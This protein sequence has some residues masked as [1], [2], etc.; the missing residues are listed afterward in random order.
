[1]PAVATCASRQVH[2]LLEIQ[3]P[4]NSGVGSNLTFCT[5]DDLSGFTNYDLNSLLFDEDI[6]GTWSEGPLTDQLDDLTDNI[7]DI[8]AIRDRYTYGTF[9][10]EYTVFPSH[11][12]CTISTTEVQ[13]IFLPVLQGTMETINF[14]AG[15]AQHTINITNY[16]L[17]LIPNGTYS[18]TYELTSA[19]GTTADTAPL[20]LKAD[21]TGSFQI[22]ANLVTL[23]EMT[24]LNITT[25]GTMVCADIQVAPVSFVV[26]DPIATVTD[27]CEE[28][29]L[30]V[31]LTNIFD[32][33]SGPANGNYDITYTL[34]APSGAIDTN[35]LNTIVFSSGN[36]T[37]TIPA[38][39][40]TETGN[41]NIDFDIASGF[42][43]DCQIAA[44]A[45]ITPI[46]SA[47][48]L[49][50]IVNNSCNATQ[51]DVLVNAPLLV[52]G[53]YIVSY[54]V[55]S[56]ENNAVLI[57]NTINFA[58]GTAN[59][60][61]DVATLVQGNYTINVRSTQNDTTP[62]RID[63]DFEL[64]EN[65]AIEGVPAL[66]NAEAV[67]FFCL[68]SF[69]PSSPTLGDIEV[70]ANG[71]ILF[72]DT[73]TDMAILPLGT[74]LVDNEDYFISNIDP[75]NN[76]EGSDRVQVTVILENP[77][78][79]MVLDEN[80]DFCASDNPTVNNLNNSI[81]GSGN[82]VWFELES[83]G[84]ALEGS[85][86]LVDGKSYFA[87]RETDTQ[88]QSTER[89]EVTAIVYS[90]ELAS[91]QL[92]DL[93]LCGLD[94]PTVSNL[95]DIE[96]NNTFEI[97]WYDTLENGTPLNDTVL[98]I[99]NTTYYAE[100]FDPTTGCKNL[101]RISVTV[102]LTDCDP[103]DYGFFIPDGF[104]PNSD[105]RN[106]TFFIPDIE[107]IFPDYTLEILN[108]YGTRLFKGDRNAPAWDGSNGS[109]KATNGVY[110]YIIDYNKKGHT[111]IQGRLYLNR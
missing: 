56:Q 5:T 41:Y 55:V 38:N 79:P 23:N 91:I 60:Q 37:F 109:G 45:T 74:V 52:D 103:E 81:S 35:T 67:Q 105:G 90:L 72:Y 7:I 63:F 42:P 69:A 30:T 59:Y 43:L 10:F 66:P 70:S 73:A 98:L 34:N 61:I 54:E 27:T 29:D 68:N 76:C 99:L 77:D 44:T 20:V 4:A 50:L 93:A 19:S 32:A 100:S 51:I 31:S 58:G 107:V 26:S 65:F 101:E 9:T 25:L 53:G 108:R 18:A 57:D 111:P 48:D 21:G 11:A 28:Q 16:D 104:S 92:N 89:S 80:P 87:T 78:A 8:E 83:G 97:L 82:I 14:C 15:P 3:R 64:N 96:G 40:I 22:D 71:Q 85:T 49:S 2:L 86:L 47:I 36:G 33:S 12:V 102:D 95:R 84:I 94:N 39:E 88:C 6:N 110:F 46:P 62:C 106:D 1:M 13:I 75:N 24:T 17:T